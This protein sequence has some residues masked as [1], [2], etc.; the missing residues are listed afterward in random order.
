[1]KSLQGVLL[2]AAV[3][4]A[5]VSAACEP[6]S[7]PPWPYTTET[8]DGGAPADDGGSDDAS[9]MGMSGAGG[10]AAN[11]TPSPLRCDGGLCDTD[12][13]SLCQVGN[14]R[15]A[16]GWRFPLTVIALISAVGVARA[17][18]RRKTR[19]SS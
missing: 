6:T 14:D 8:D 10:I 19:R 5:L 13:Y 9:D 12:N 15:G 4:L 17:R 18:T 3:T 16:S 1:M 2:A 7:V 11:Y